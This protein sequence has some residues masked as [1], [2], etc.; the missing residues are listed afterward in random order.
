M[1]IKTYVYFAKNVKLKMKYF[2]LD[3]TDYQVYHGLSWLDPNLAWWQSHQKKVMFE[4][5]L[6]FVF[7]S[8][9]KKLLSIDVRFVVKHLFLWL[10]SLKK[11]AYITDVIF[12]TKHLFLYKIFVTKHLF[13]RFE[14]LKKSAYIINVIFVT[15]HL[16]LCFKSFN[17]LL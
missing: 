14:S 17:V 12:V 8:K 9:E 16:F 1:K 11:S 4:T 13:L 6:Y 15:K 10:E 5:E 7:K 3:F 2:H